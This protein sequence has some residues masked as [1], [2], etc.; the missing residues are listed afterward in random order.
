MIRCVTSILSSARL[1]F[2]SAFTL[3]LGVLTFDAHAADGDLSPTT[4]TL[5]VRAIQATSPF[6]QERPRAENVATKEA[7]S[8]QLDPE[9][10]DIE[11]RLI[12][13]PFSRFQLLA[14]KNETITIKQKNSLQLPNGQKLILRP[15]YMDHKKVGLWLNWRDKD[16]S[17]ILNTRVHF[18]SSESVITGT[19]CSHDQGL[20][21]AIK[22]K[23]V[24]TPD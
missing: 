11:A 22:A 2:V 9:L 18:D 15:M 3:L 14:S 19:D 21:L 13:L 7:T 5:F 10:K 1:T 24:V 8:S 16:G 20:I 4:V 23:Q 6:Q 12:N 17:E